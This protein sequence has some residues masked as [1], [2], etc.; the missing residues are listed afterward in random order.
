MS[1][2]TI[3]GAHLGRFPRNRFYKPC[4]KFLAFCPWQARAE[5]DG[6]INN[7]SIVCENLY[8]ISSCSFPSIFSVL[9]WREKEEKLLNI[10]KDQERIFVIFCFRFVWTFCH[11]DFRMRVKR[12]SGYQNHLNC[13]RK[14]VC[15]FKSNFWKKKVLVTLL[16]KS[17]KN[18][19]RSLLFEEKMS[20]YERRTFF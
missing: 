15:K 11:I 16:C 7:G 14:N 3:F 5:R 8:C 12:L 10:G 19:A 1:P 4:Y 20:V 6:E 9:F 18:C 2:D 17:D 13:I